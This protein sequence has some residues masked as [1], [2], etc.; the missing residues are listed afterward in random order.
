MRSAVSL[1]AIAGVSIWIAIPAAAANA[2]NASNYSTVLA[3]AQQART[4]GRH[5]YSSTFGGVWLDPTT[6]MAHIQVT[7]PA[8]GA[9]IRSLLASP[10]N[11]V[12]DVVGHSEAQL[13]AL[14]RQIDR[15]HKYLQDRGV[16]IVQDGPNVRAN[17]VDVQV[18]SLSATGLTLMRSRYASDILNVVAA[19]A[20]PRAAGRYSAPPPYVGGMEVDDEAYACTMGFIGNRLI[21]GTYVYYVITAGHCFPNGDIAFHQV[22]PAGSTHVGT[23]EDNAF[24]NGTTA[25]ALDIGLEAWGAAGASNLIVTTD[26]TED[27]VTQ[28]DGDPVVG[29]IGVCKSGIT[30]DETCFQVAK[31]GQTVT[32]PAEGSFAQ[33]TIIDQTIGGYYGGPVVVGFG[34]SG[35]P[36][37][38]VAPD[39]SIMAHGIT[40][41]GLFYSGTNQNDGEIIYSNISQV[42]QQLPGISI[43]T[44]PPV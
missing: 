14:Q 32:Y 11:S 37:F 42:I 8:A 18:Q 4:I 26:P 24:Q 28:L 30:T 29:E 27:P 43:Q 12:I 33:T 17:R 22:N 13:V 16:T 21:A 25:D 6:G 1:F 35:G 39:G 23:V 38:R 5:A 36:V 40:S 20:E 7:N 34:D 15:D 31:T 3:D 10:G 19:N 9:M 2:S 44:Y 41:G